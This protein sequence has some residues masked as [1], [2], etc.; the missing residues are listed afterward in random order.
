MFTMAWLDRIPASNIEL[1]TIAAS[2]ALD[3]EKCCDPL[4]R[5]MHNAFRVGACS[6]EFLKPNLTIGG[7]VVHVDTGL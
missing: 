6:L 3:R 5:V 7:L 4:L 1:D 2:F